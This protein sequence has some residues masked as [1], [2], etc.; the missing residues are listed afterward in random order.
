MQAPCTLSSLLL[1]LNIIIKRQTQLRL[2]N[3]YNAV[4]INDHANYVNSMGKSELLSPELYCIITLST[5]HLAF[6]VYQIMIK[7][8]AVIISE[9]VIRD[10]LIITHILLRALSS[11]NILLFVIAVNHLFW[12]DEYCELF[13]TE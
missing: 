5:I 4:G 10:S 2:Q 8:S 9:I 7:Y 3:E 1:V 12:Y 11:F 13:C 6:T